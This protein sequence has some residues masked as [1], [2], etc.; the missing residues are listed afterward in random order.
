MLNKH[1]ERLEAALAKGGVRNVCVRKE[2]GDR[3]KL[4]L[5]WR[6]GS[7]SFV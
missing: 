7:F 2:L 4:L 6:H 3:P 5:H 1:A